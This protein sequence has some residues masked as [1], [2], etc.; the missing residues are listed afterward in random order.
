MSLT[1]QYLGGKQAITR[2]KVALLMRI[3]RNFALKF[4]SLFTALLLY[5]YVQQE[6]NPMVARV[7]E[8]TISREGLPPDVSVDVDQPQIKVTV[9][10]P[11]PVVDV[12][13]E[14]AVRVVADLH[15]LPSDKITTARVPMKY[16][17]HLTP[18]VQTLLSIDPSPLPRLE[19]QVFPQRSKELQVEAHYPKEAHAGYH[20]G[21]Y[22]V[23]PERVTIS[24]RIDRV[25]RVTQIVA[26]ANSLETGGGIDNDFPLSA[27]DSDNNPVDGITM[28][29]QT[30]H[31][32]VPIVEDAY[33]KILS[34]SAIIS[35]QIQSGYRITNVTVEPKQVRVV[36]R[37]QLI[38]T[39]S[40]LSTEEI[41]VHDV[42][43]NKVVSVPLVVPNKVGVTDIAT[44]NPITRIEVT[45]TVEK[46]GASSSPPP[47]QPVTGGP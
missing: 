28:T 26:D 36:G 42:T 34:V 17:I 21:P 27:R 8:V 10:G 12:L 38:D 14:S 41:S 13:K 5:L 7:F 32:T 19:V 30:A 45:L 40:T 35:D 33:S 11:Q 22:S 23:K 24:G 16:D 15:S 6:R 37:P 39:L 4:I 46:V 20:Y 44:H 1:T 47:G 9:T 2:Q 31:V 3:R 43:E 29:V 18:E 25:K